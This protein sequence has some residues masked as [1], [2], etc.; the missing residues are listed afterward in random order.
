LLQAGTF[1]DWAEVSRVMT[2][3][4]ATEGTIAPDGPI[5]SAVARIEK[6][7]A[8]QLERSVAALRLVQDEIAYM[9]NG[10]EGG[11]Y[12]PQTPA[13]TWDKRYGDC[14][15]KT[16]L[17]LAM[18]REMGI[19]AEAVVVASRTGDVVPEML[20]MPGAFDH[21]IVRAVIDGTEYWLDG[22]SSGASMQVVGEVPPFHVALPLRDG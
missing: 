1:A 10:M 4:F 13:E 3:L 9:L 8:G 15:A 14:K 21:V 7:H 11:N 16:V 20:P 2:P 18:L 12:I 22:T 17:L 19:E 6:D 5:A